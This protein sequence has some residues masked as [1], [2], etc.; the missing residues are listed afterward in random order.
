MIKV[1]DHGYVELLRVCGAD[2]DII[3]AARMSTG[4]DF[5]GWGPREDG[6]AGDEKLLSYLWRHGHLSPFEQVSLT[7]EIQLPI[8]VARELMRHRVVSFNEMSARYVP[9]PDLNYIPTVE[10]LMMHS[11][12][13]KQAGVVA[14][15]A[16]L[17]EREAERFRIALFHQYAAAQDQYEYALQAGVPKELARAVVPVGRFTRVCATSNLRGWLSVLQQRLHK[18]AQWEIQEY[19]RAIGSC[20]SEHFPRTWALFEEGLQ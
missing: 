19:A 4:G 3:S 20:V 9:L 7:F 15:A 6:S 13:N 11:K 18:D 12:T 2:S 8:F 1:L 16:E 17:T 5:R 10:R 14:G